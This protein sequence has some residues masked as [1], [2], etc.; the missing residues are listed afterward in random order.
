[1]A[2]A[3]PVPM[4]PLFPRFKRVAMLIEKKRRLVPTET[5][6]IV[7]DLLV[8]YFPDILSADFTARMESELDEIA[9]ESKAW[10]PVINGFYKRF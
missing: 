2:L 6:E 10:V 5:G 7:N 4:L 3:V 9:K 1:M 8:E